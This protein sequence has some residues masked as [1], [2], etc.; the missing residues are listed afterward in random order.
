MN[1]LDFISR[2]VHFGDGGQ[3][4]HR[5]IRHTKVKLNFKFDENV[6]S[7]VIGL[8][9]YRA[10]VWKVA[11]A[12]V[13]NSFADCM[14]CISKARYVCKKPNRAAR[15][16]IGRNVRTAPRSEGDEGPTF[17]STSIPSERFPLMV[18]IVL[19]IRVWISF[20]DTKPR[21]TL[22]T[23]AIYDWFRSESLVLTSTTVSADSKPFLAMKSRTPK[24]S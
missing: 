2:Y 18:F 4:G 1:G 13:P 9:P 23:T 20:F 6:P 7:V 11:I 10:C 24:S 3:R 16:A 22:L 14:E 12:T 15:R 5:K 17:D 21:I 8:V 19:T